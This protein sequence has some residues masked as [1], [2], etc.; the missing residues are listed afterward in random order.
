MRLRYIITRISGPRIDGVWIADFPLGVDGKRRIMLDPDV[1]EHYVSLGWLELD[2]TAPPPD[3]DTIPD[4]DF[5]YKGARLHNARPIVNRY[6][7]NH[8]LTDS[9]PVRDKGALIIVTSASSIS[10]TL[11]RDWKEGE[12]AII[13]RAGTG[14]VTFALATGATR[15]L[16]DSRSTHTKIAERH[17]EV[18]V[19][20]IE[21]SNGN[22]AVWSIEG[23]TA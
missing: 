17:S 6:S 3:I 22:S 9:A 4:A 16:P 14:D 15:V 10:I 2:D 20:V 12:G 19:R 1:A 11:P 21:N 23:P 8:T 13:R 7:V 5:D 18:L